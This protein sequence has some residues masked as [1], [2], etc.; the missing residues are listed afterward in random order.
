MAKDIINAFD[1]MRFCLV[2]NL[3]KGFNWPVTRLPIIA[4]RYVRFATTCFPQKKLI[5]NTDGRHLG[6]VP[7]TFVSVFIHIQGQPM[8]II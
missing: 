2:I 8:D 1:Y 5:S 4:T 7:S 3:T 6:H